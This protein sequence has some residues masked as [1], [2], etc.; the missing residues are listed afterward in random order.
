MQGTGRRR[1]VSKLVLLHCKNLDADANSCWARLAL[2]FS[3]LIHH[4]SP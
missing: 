2:I 3:H 1:A 4:P